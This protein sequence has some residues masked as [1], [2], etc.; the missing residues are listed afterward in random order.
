M[1]IRSLRRFPGGRRVV[2]G[3]EGALATGDVGGVLTVAY[4][5]SA[6]LNGMDGP[7]PDDLWIAGAKG[8]LLHLAGDDIFVIPA[9]T[10]RDLHGVVYLG[11]CDVVAFGDEGT[12][13]HYD[14]SEFTDR[15]RPDAKLDLLAGA[16]LG[17]G[18]A[19]A[20]RTYVELPRFV[21][22]PS[23]VD[24]AADGSWSGLGLAWSYPG[25]Q[26]LSYQVLYLSS[27][28]GASFWT[29]MAAGTSR[30]VTFP[31]F[32]QLIG[33]DPVPAGTKRVNLTAV[34]SPGFSID[35]YTSTDTGFYRREAF[36]VNLAIFDSVPP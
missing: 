20:G 25:E 23:F 31:Q 10:D 34:R 22:F 19:L 13:L 17:G 11:P 9:P 7:S 16:P 30:D 27:A 6:D 15:S 12:V 8:T 21:E 4:P 28:A 24:P 33:Y 35:R 26:P 18:V 29:V 36:A 1:E 14:C 2:A 32:G 5:V 3:R